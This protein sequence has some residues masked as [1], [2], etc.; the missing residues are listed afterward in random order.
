MQ[1]PVSSPSSTDAKKRKGNAAVQ[2]FCHLLHSLPTVKYIFWM[3]NRVVDTN[4]EI[5]K[6]FHK[7][8]HKTMPSDDIDR[9][10]RT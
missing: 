6:Q 3:M 7:A 2:K 5:T 4:S 9:L 8:T 10:T 1:K